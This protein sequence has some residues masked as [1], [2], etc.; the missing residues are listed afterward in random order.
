MFDIL[1]LEDKEAY[2]NKFVAVNTS[3]KTLYWWHNAITVK[4]QL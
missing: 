4:L 3:S 2:A 1:F